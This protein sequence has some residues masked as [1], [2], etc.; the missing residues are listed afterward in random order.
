MRK[1][2]GLFVLVALAGCAKRDFRSQEFESNPDELVAAL[3]VNPATLDPAVSQDT[4]T[5][6][7]MGH[8][9]EGLVG[10]SADNKLV[11]RLAESW[12]ISYDGLTYTFLLRDAKFHNGK[13]V[14]AIDVLASWERAAR[15]DVASPV[16]ENYLGDIVGMK[17]LLAGKADQLAGVEVVKDLVLRVRLKQPRPSFL[18]KLT[19]PT[20]A[21]VPAGT[22][23]ILDIG[24]MVG[25][26]PYRAVLYTPEAEVKLE[27]NDAYYGAKPKVAKLTY[28][29]VKDPSTRL[30]LF[31]TGRLDWAGLTQQDYVGMKGTAKL[32]IADRPATFYIGMNG[33][34]YKPFAD[35]RVRQAFNHAV[36]RSRV[37]SDV[38][39]DLGTPAQGIIP[40]VVPQHR[41]QKAVL[42]F[43]VARAKQLLRS[44]GWEGKLPPLDLWVSDSLGDRRRSAE[45]VVSMLRENLGV[46]IQMRLVEASVVIQKATKRELGFFFGSWYAD[47]LDPENFLSVLLSSYGQNRTNWNNAEFDRLCREADSMPDGPERQ[48]K[49]F[50]A[51]NLALQDAPWIPLYHPREAIA[52][53]KGVEGLETN[54]FGMMP[55]VNVSRIP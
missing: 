43:D 53:R 30:T 27:R 11:P 55:P 9:F 49:Y 18:G 17:E 47:Y 50:Q 12:S 20:A 15:K 51:E 54:A 38:L 4:I 25:T 48:L 52:V 3:G 13:S 39:G 7:L 22:G 10:W 40:D 33:T 41:G 23:P 44:S 35:R 45:L 5:N 42:E 6:D 37:V 1:I 21:V 28:R 14:T 29:V 46:P 24:A 16:V 32:L 34:V 36:D 2:L 19:Y 31:K 8:V 26:G